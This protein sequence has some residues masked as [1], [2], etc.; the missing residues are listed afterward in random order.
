MSSSNAIGPLVS[1]VTPNDG[2]DSFL[3]SFDDS[4]DDIISQDDTTVTPNTAS[5]SNE[6]ASVAD[7]DNDDFPIP[8]DDSDD[9]PSP[10]ANFYKDSG[11]ASPIIDY[12]TL[13]GQLSESGKSQQGIGTFG[14]SATDIGAFATN[15]TL[16]DANLTLSNTLSPSSVTEIA[17]GLGSN[18]L[19][20]SANSVL[21]NLVS[22]AGQDQTYSA[23]LPDGTAISTL[24]NRNSLDA[25]V[26]QLTNA[27][28]GQGL[29]VNG[30]SPLSLYGDNT[31]ALVSG[32]RSSLLEPRRNF[33][34]NNPGA[35]ALISILQFYNPYLNFNNASS[36]PRASIPG[37]TRDAVSNASFGRDGGGG[38]G[39]GS[40]GSGG[41]NPRDQQQNQSRFSF[42]T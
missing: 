28:T 12:Q 39:G 20:Q 32:L 33:D 10:M 42:N 2:G 11:I 16:V 21:N 31:S 26:K 40:G 15:K 19:S 37:I 4:P 7:E 34:P 9:A 24:A 41:R 13:A 22:H 18:N 30:Y 6:P 14:L 1:S 23:T 35:S 29:A 8:D 25:Y 27:S 36:S 38:N 17:S 3:A 5:P